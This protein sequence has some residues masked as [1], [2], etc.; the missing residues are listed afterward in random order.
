MATRS[1]KK[2]DSYQD[3]TQAIELIHKGDYKKAQSALEG[4]NKK[5]DDPRLS[6]RIESYLKI[7]ERSLAPEPGAAKDAESGYDRG[8][9]AHNQGDYESAKTSFKAALKKADDKESAQILVALA[10]V[11]AKSGESTAALTYLKK[12]L[13]TDASV[14][15]LALGDPDFERLRQTDAFRKLVESFE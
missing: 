12:G 13:Q 10:A 3:F 8:V 2:S 5:A 4:L 15:F 1:T 11:E 7:C 9:V 6:S 14:R